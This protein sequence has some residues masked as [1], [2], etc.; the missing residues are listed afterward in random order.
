LGYMRGDN[1]GADA[2]SSQRLGQRVRE[3]LGKRGVRK[4]Q[5]WS[6]LDIERHLGQEMG[7][8]EFSAFQA[9]LSCQQEAQTELLKPLARSLA[10]RSVCCGDGPRWRADHVVRFVGAWVSLVLEATRP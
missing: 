6:A 5:W 2:V 7:V 9:A 10:Q 3:D 8:S 4:D 1:P